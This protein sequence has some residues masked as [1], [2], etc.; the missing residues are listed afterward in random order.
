MKV[1]QVT[2]RFWDDNHEHGYYQSPVFATRELAEAFVKA[3]KEHPNQTL[4][5][6]WDFRDED[7]AGNPALNDPEIEEWE[8]HESF[9]PSELKEA[10]AYLNITYT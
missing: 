6:W 2:K 7:W 1:Y 3:I 4:Y 9:D 8:I 10:G 5:W